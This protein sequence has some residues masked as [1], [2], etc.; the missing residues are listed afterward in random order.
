M[1]ISFIYE[2]ALFIRRHP[3]LFTVVTRT[4]RPTQLSQTAGKTTLSQ[5]SVFVMAPKID[6]KL[7]L[8]LRQSE[9]F[10]Q[11]NRRLF[12]YL[13]KKSFYSLKIITFPTLTYAFKSIF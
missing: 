10:I 2:I 9:N 3:E 4:Q 11:F 5:N 12:I 8:Q 13:I 1:T 6:N 7:P